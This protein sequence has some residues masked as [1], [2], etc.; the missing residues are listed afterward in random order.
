MLTLLIFAIDFLWLDL[1]AR[2]GLPMCVE[3]SIRNSTVLSAKSTVHTK[4]T[5]ASVDIS[6]LRGSRSSVDVPEQS[7]LA[8]SSERPRPAAESLH[9]K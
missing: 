9:G 5:W 3:M 7:L 6:A 2:Q 8:N 4:L 1:R